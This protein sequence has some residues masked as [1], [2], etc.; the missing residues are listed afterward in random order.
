MAALSRT[1]LLTVTAA[2]ILTATSVFAQSPP[3]SGAAEPAAQA[4]DQK[5]PREAQPERP[6]VATHAYTV[7]PGIVELETGFQQQHPAPSLNL[8]GLPVLFKIGLSSRLQLDIAPGWL[9][10]AG[11]SGV[12]EG[13]TDLVIGVKWR[14][15]DRSSVLGAFAVQP[16]VSLATG[17]ADKG[18]GIGSESLTVLAI[19][20]RNIG[21]VALDLNLGYTRRGGDGTV[22]PNNATMWTL[23]T[24]FPVYGRLNW[25]AECFGYPRTTGP[26]GEP[27]IVAFL[28]GPTVVVHKSVVLDAGVVLNIANYGGTAVYGGVTW[29]IGHAWTPRP[30][31]SPAAKQ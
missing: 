19:S 22:L 6:T 21:P 23:S 11:E 12:S 25:A 2:L 9:R 8:V 5:D 4:S 3:P 13:L 18:T 29:N 7:A 1:V 15:V 28:T 31:K 27:G 20:S 14:L 17:S 24:G 10:G 16:S 30:V 26:S